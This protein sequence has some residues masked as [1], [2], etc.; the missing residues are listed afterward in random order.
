M[1]AYLTMCL[2]FSFYIFLSA[3]DET[4]GKGN[5]Q[6]VTVTT[7][8]NSNNSNGNNT[9]DSQGFV[10][11]P[12]SASRFL[13]QSTFGSTYD[14]ISGLPAIG[15]ENWIDN[16]LTLPRGALL[17]DEIEQMRLIKNNAIGDPDGGA[18]NFYFDHAW[19]D[20]HISNDDQLRQ[21][22]A[23]A[24]S[25]FFV[26]SRFAGFGDNPFA[27]G[28]YYDMLLN[29]ALGNYRTLL[30][31][32]T[33]HSAMAEY[34]T[35]MDNPK[36]DTI[37]DIDYSNGFPDTLNITYIF[38][39]ENY[40]REVMQLFSIGLIEL[41]P[42]GTPALDNNGN[43]I[44]TYDNM[45]IAEF[46]K[47]FTGMSY[48]D[49][50]NFD[51]YPISGAKTYLRPMQIYNEYHQSGT[52]E[53]LNGFVVPDRNPVDGYADVADALDNIFNHP[54]IGPF[55]GKFLI[56]RFVTS[57]PS[58]EYV[59]RITE[60]F[61][62][63]SQYGNTRGDMSALI[64]AIL[65]DEEARS[66]QS[67]NDDNFGKLREPFV[68]YMQLGKAFNITTPNGG[69]RNVMINVYDNV[70]QRPLS[71]PSVFNFFQSDYQPIGRIENADKVAPEFQIANTQTISGYLNGLNDWL[72]A[73]NYVD[74]WDIYTNEDAYLDYM[75]SFDFT[76]EREMTSDETVPQ[77]VERLNL[78]LAH[79]KLSDET[80]ETIEDVILSHP[81]PELNCV[82]EYDWDCPGSV[83]WCI[84]QC[85]GDPDC[86]E[87]C[88]TVQDCEDNRQ[89]NIQYCLDNI[90]EDNFYRIRLAI[91]L[92][93]ASPEYLIN[94]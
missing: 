85:N 67:G 19:W 86:I 90:E 53:L 35:Y 22:L 17:T 73:N 6:N 94:R 52:K 78:V 7:S 18:F 33:Y 24:L 38:P 8:N 29:N 34:L 11:N 75:P 15:I 58:P 31:S 50:M 70:Q 91:L 16:Q 81:I 84:N 63:N 25:E 37:Y 49:N 88:G 27:L 57:N 65:L 48:G 2:V 4:L 23:F 74:Q 66:C 79:G 68:R 5:I 13:S 72:M 80:I 60:A 87:D 56:Q 55:L 14:E 89:A 62:G 32:V 83:A 92:V 82:E 26:I 10:P 30:D 1:K 39:D 51:G 12:N 64:K 45:D 36:A 69:H 93:M 59:E 76:A 28:S 3:Q 71:S 43:E 9:V 40:A 41:N 54:N 61:N 47:I 21:R 42:D 46:A 77:L 44:P 20:Y